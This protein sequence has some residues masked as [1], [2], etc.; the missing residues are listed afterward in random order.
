[1]LP[2]P[3]LGFMIMKAK[4][5]FVVTGASSGIG[6]SISDLLIS[7]GYT[8]IGLGREVSRLKSSKNIIAD[9]SKESACLQACSE[10]REY[11]GNLPLHG[12]VNNAGV[13]DRLSFM[14]TSFQIWERHFQTNLMSAI[15]LTHE[16]YP[17]LKAVKGSSV[18][19]ISSTLG[20]RP[21]ADTAA[22]SAMKAAMVNWT[23][24]LALEWAKDGIRV[25]CICPGLVDTPIHAFHSQDESKKVDAHKA[26]PLGRMGTPKE[27]AQGSWFLLSEDSSW[28]TGAVN[29]IDGGIIL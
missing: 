26:Q 25:N 19:N 16:L 17:Q 10:I 2:G 15:R 1:M 11:L 8:V 14:D 13:V 21:I 6:R 9:L 22:Y 24:T 7:K 27:I 29:V 28:T 3:L 4:G 12:L 18:L 23:K 20:I 5:A